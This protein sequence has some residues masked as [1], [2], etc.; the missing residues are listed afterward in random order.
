MQ[1]VGTRLSLNG[2]VSSAALNDVVTIA[3]L[4]IVVGIA[5][6]DR[7]V[8]AIA[9]D[10]RSSGRACRVQHIVTDTAIDTFDT[11]RG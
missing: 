4:Q 8:T 7:V 1:L 9:K 10:G 3:A 2:V 11:V 5:T 6:R